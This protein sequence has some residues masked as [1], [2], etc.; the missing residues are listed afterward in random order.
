MNMWNII[1]VI[2]LLVAG[3]ALL[4][5]VLTNGIDMGLPDNGVPPNGEEQTVQLFY[6]D[7]EEDTD[8]GGNIMC[9][10]EGLVAVER[11]IPDTETPIEDTIKL[12]INGDLTA[13]EE[14][15]GITTEY[16]LPG[17]EL[18]GARL[19]D[20]ALTLEFNDPQS[21]LSG[22]SCRVGILWFQIEETA[23]QFPTVQTVQFEPEEL[24]QP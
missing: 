1:L 6:Y 5:I 13:E 7:P 21:Q 20:G 9:S 3:G 14:A 11:T 2:A 18:Q 17:V 8:A 15:Q 10:R 23:L 4:W 22:G 19:E 12:L 24:F 16:P